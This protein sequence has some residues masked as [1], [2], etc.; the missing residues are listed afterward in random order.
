MA[1]VKKVNDET[2]EDRVVIKDLREIL[3]DDEEARSIRA[4]LNSKMTIKGAE[5]RC[6]D[7]NGKGRVYNDYGRQLETNPYNNCVVRYDTCPTCDGAGLVG[8]NTHKEKGWDK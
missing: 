2:I 4:T 3:G 7:C 6:Y 5:Y 8:F 1:K